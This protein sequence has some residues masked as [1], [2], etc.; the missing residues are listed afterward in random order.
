[1]KLLLA[2]NSTG[3]LFQNDVVDVTRQFLQ[4][5]ADRIY[6]TLMAAYESKNLTSLRVYSEMFQELL[7]DLDRLLR[8]DDHFLL[9]RWLESAKAL[10][11]TS[12]ERQKYEYNARNQITIWGPQGQIVDYA[13]KQWAGVVEDFF[14][15]RWEMFLIEMEAALRD[16]RTLNETKVR[17][18]IFR[19]VELAFNTDN[20]R[21]PIVAEGNALEIARTL[22]RK[23]SACSETL[24][25]LP[26]K[27][28]S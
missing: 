3:K 9:G 24:K 13:N 26:R 1:M 5:T 10:G 14:L 7:T 25:I 11:E 19:L 27:S 4:N 20:K 15:P 8:S 16:N 6:L 12:L 28:K 21:Y 23:W 17:S 22:Y 2:A 18:K